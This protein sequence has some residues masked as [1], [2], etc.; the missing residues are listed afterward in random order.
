MELEDESSLQQ[1]KPALRPTN[2]NIGIYSTVCTERCLKHLVR[3]P[4]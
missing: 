4:N 3:R 2:T 1:V